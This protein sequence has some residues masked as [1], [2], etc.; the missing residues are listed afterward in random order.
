[1]QTYKLTVA[2]DGTRYAGWQ[3]QP[4]GVTIQ[5]VLE[6]AITSVVG[7]PVRIAGSGR[8][9]AGVHALGQVASGRWNT[10]LTPDVLLRAINANLPLDIRLL[11]IQAVCDAFHA[12][13]DAIEKCYRYVLEHGAVHNV[14]RR[15]YC[16]FLPGSLDHD[17]MQQGANMLVGT[18]DFASFQASGSPRASTVRTVTKLQVCREDPQHIAIEIA[19]N[20][21]LYNMVRNIVGTLVLVG[22][23]RERPEWVGRV[24]RQ[25]DRRSA[26]R[27]APPQGLFLVNVAY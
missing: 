27:T 5:Q 19:G 13:R 17:P 11:S 26:G 4:N 24:L 14:F 10:R 2:Y 1:M 21:F 18:H 3:V 8:T 20:G 9:D 6:D 22:Q 15:D 23:G 25:Q 16:W 7:Q 12:R